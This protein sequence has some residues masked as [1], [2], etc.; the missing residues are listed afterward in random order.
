MRANKGQRHSTHRTGRVARSCRGGVNNSRTRIE[1]LQPT[2]TL[3][4]KEIIAGIGYNPCRGR[5]K[6]HFKPNGSQNKNDEDDDN[7]KTD[8]DIKEEKRI[9]A[10]KESSR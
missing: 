1:N 5:V 8:T 3:Q 2:K 6:K 10:E 9:R 7:Y 4:H